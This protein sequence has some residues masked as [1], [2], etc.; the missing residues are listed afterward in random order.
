MTYKELR[1]DI[2]ARFRRPFRTLGTI[3]G[4]RHSRALKG[5]ANIKRPFRTIRT[6]VESFDAT[7][8]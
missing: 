6:V 1:D 8:R 5:P 3:V 7:G 2:R 4:N